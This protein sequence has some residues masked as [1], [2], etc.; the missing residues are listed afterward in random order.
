MLLCGAAIGWGLRVAERQRLGNANQHQAS[1]QARADGWVSRC[2]ATLE[3]Q[4]VETL[5]WGRALRASA[6][7]PRA[8]KS[9]LARMN[10]QADTPAREV[11]PLRF[12]PDPAAVLALTRLEADPRAAVPNAGQSLAMTTTLELVTAAFGVLRTAEPKGQAPTAPATEATAPS[13]RIRVVHSLTR[14]LSLAEGALR[15][16][17]IPERRAEFAGVLLLS[18]AVFRAAPLVPD[19]ATDEAVRRLFLTLLA[20]APL[21]VAQASVS[22]AEGL[23]SEV[24]Q[25]RA[26]VVETL[27]SFVLSRNPAPESTLAALEEQVLPLLTELEA[28]QLCGRAPERNVARLAALSSSLRALRVSRRALSPRAGSNY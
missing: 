27:A 5:D 9:D 2:E 17:R 4:E 23:A 10:E 8:P 13:E 25:R 14:A 11:L 15:E 20:R 1:L 16:P 18:Q 7:G 21:F 12:S 22:A 19:A 6:L 26:L 24:L 3:R 28:A